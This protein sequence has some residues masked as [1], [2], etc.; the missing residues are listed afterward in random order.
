MTESDPLSDLP[1]IGGSSSRLR[2]GNAV[3][4][5][6]RY[7]LEEEAGRG[8]MGVVWRARDT[9]LDDRPVA[10]KF[11]PEILAA[12]EIAL[13]DLRRE[14]RTMLELTYPGI[15]RLH[16][17]EA[18][19]GLLFLVMEWLEGPTLR[20]ALAEC[21]QTERGLSAE[22]ALWMLEEVAAAMDHAHE[23]GVLHRDIKPANLMLTKPAA[24]P[25]SQC[26]AHV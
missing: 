10:L 21:R 15:V 8:G 3:G 26:D 24:A 13:Q 18:D 1:T 6:G 11:L 17:L 2:A 5:G 22:D 16:T 12:D 19:E 23:Q 7:V 20:G 9:Q 4:P 25:L 14:A